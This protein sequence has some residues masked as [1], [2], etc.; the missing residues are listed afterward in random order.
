MESAL[1]FLI[2]KACLKSQTLLWNKAKREIKVES[3]SNEILVFDGF[4]MFEKGIWNQTRRS[5]RGNPTKGML[6][7]QRNRLML[8]KVV[9][10]AW[11]NCNTFCTLQFLL[12][13]FLW[14]WTLTIYQHWTSTLTWK[15]P[16][17]EKFSQKWW[18][19][20]ITIK[21]R[22]SFWFGSSCKG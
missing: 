20:S 12:R 18:N 16:V 4:S 19:I 2:T 9:Q 13:A 6:L 10:C 17:L 8:T 1:N 5:S 21:F 15:I 22:W 14:W 11:K 7:K 3:L